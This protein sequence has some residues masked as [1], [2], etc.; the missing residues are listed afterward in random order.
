M[1]MD[2]CCYL[3]NNSR[4]D[5]KLAKAEALQIG[6]FHPNWGAT[7]DIYPP[8]LIKAGQQA[9]SG[10]T[11]G[12][13]ITG[14]DEDFT[15]VQYAVMHGAETLGWVSI[16]AEIPFLLRSIDLSAYSDIATTIFTLSEGGMHSGLTTQRVTIGNWDY[17]DPDWH[18]P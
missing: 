11:F 4:Y 1:T 14:W 6:A 7:W 16:R 2:Y 18:W 12:T 8:S 15:L 17:D 3:S 13:S 10:P 9:G 5:L